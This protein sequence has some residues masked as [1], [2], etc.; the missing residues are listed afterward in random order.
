[1][2]ALFQ[3][4]LYFGQDFVEDYGT[5]DVAL[6]AY[7]TGTSTEKIQQALSEVRELLAK[8]LSEDELDYYLMHELDCSYNTAADGLTPSQWLDM[9][10]KQMENWL[11]KEASG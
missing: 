10:A 1:M 5:A 9:V 11:K 6:D 7:L 3:M 2:S 8:N 4:M